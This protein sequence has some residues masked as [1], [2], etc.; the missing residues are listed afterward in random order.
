M[1]QECK[2]KMERKCKYKK[3]NAKKWKQQIQKKYCACCLWP[4]P[5]EISLLA[6]KANFGEFAVNFRLQSRSGDS[7]GCPL[8]VPLFLLLFCFLFA[9]VL[10]FVEVFCNFGKNHGKSRPFQ[11]WAGTLALRNRGLSTLAGP[12]LYVFQIP[13]KFLIMP[14]LVTNPKIESPNE[15]QKFHRKKTT[16]IC[17]YTKVGSS[18]ILMKLPKRNEVLDLRRDAKWTKRTQAPGHIGNKGTIAGLWKKENAWRG[19]APVFNNWPKICR[20]ANMIFFRFSIW[21]NIGTQQT[22]GVQPPYLLQGGEVDCVFLHSAAGRPRPAAYLPPVFCCAHL[23]S[24]ILL[25]P[26]SFGKYQMML[27]VHASNH[28]FVWSELNEK[29]MSWGHEFSPDPNRRHVMRLRY[30]PSIVQA[31]IHKMVPKC[32]LKKHRNRSVCSFHLARV[33]F[34]H[35]FWQDLLKKR[36]NVTWTKGE[37]TEKAKP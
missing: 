18:R 14:I 22:A 21:S 4:F 36:L 15:K 23:A 35:I 20:K 11:F 19:L 17:C 34:G 8:S 24:K 1:Q 30:L 25:I 28:V 2:W 9:F 37:Q 3:Y 12:P 16:L 5:H 10:L 7:V 33:Q 6:H 27:V 29:S 13:S 31:D 32:P 26:E